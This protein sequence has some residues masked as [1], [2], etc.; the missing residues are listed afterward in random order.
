MKALLTNYRQTPRKVRLV[1]DLVRGKSVK[2]AKTALTFLPKKSVPAIEKLID[3]AVA[4]ARSMGVDADNLFIK[5]ITVDKGIVM[6]R[7]RPFAR[8]RAGR[9]HK[10][11]SIINIELSSSAAPKKRRGAKK[12]AAKKAE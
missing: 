2:D 10:E 8:G 1:A 11:T 6:K 4:N 3:S 12:A 9:L 5:K 7:F